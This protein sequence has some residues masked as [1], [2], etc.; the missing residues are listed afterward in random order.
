M[1]Y[2]DRPKY[3]D[4]TTTTVDWRDAKYSTP[5]KD[6]TNCGSCWA[7]TATAVYE[8]ML[9]ITYN[10]SPERLSEQEYVECDWGNGGCCG[11]NAMYAW[12]Y[13]KSVG[14]KIK[15][16]DFPYTGQFKNA[17]T[18]AT[19]CKNVCPSFPNAVKAKPPL[20]FVE[21]S[22]SSTPATVEAMKTALKKGPLAVAVSASGSFGSYKFGI[23]QPT[24]CGTALNHAVTLVGWGYDTYTSQ[25]FWL[26]R[27]SWGPDWGDKGFIKIAINGNSCNVQANVYQLFV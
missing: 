9:A 11:G 15:Y 18:G 8:S 20:N 24:A 7:F 5:V 13:S 23:L 26:I 21:L 19:P 12:R 4:N 3:I 25:E 16:N 27:N 1:S 10:T 17:T 2:Y 22:T 14:G 6:Q